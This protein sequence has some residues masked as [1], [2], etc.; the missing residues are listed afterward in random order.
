MEP[1]RTYWPLKDLAQDKGIEPYLVCILSVEGLPIKDPI[2][3]IVYDF[4]PIPLYI[5]PVYYTSEPGRF[6]FYTKGLLPINLII[7]LPIAGYKI[8][9]IG[10]YCL[11]DLPIAIVK[12]LSQLG[13]KPVPA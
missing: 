8:I 6:N 13:Q 11:L 4:N 3:L 2:G 10:P 12:L 1:A 9:Y 7:V 5:Y